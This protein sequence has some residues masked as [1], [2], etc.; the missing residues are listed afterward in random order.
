ME[1]EVVVVET[2]TPPPPAWRDIIERE[3]AADPRGKA[4]I[5]DRLGVS[6]CYVSRVLTAGK[7][8]YQAVPKKFILRVLDL[9]SDVDCPATAGRMPRAECRKANGEAPTHNPFAMRLWREC[10]VCTL[11]PIKPAP[12]AK[13]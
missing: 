10:Q 4:G 8:G 9:E 11:K 1:N 12:E 7:A 5:A 2:V 3:I 13:P 6:R